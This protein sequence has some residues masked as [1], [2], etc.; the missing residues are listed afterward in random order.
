MLKRTLLAF[1][2]FV[3]ICGIAQKPYSV[4]AESKPGDSIRAVASIL[5]EELAKAGSSKY[6][7][8]PLTAFEGSGFRL[9]STKQAEQFNIKF[10]EGLKKFGPEGIY[11]NA[12]NQSA[13]I[14]GNSAL[15]IQEGIYIYLEQLGYRWFLPGEKWTITPGLVSVFKPVSIL[16]QPDFEYRTIAN[17]HGYLNLE[18][19]KKDYDAWYKANRM[20]GAYSIFLGHNYDNIV[21]ARADIFKQHPEYFAE[22][23]VKGNLP[24]TAKFNVANKDL[25]NLVIDVAKKDIEGQIKAN[26]SPLFFSMEPSDGGGYCQKPECLAIGGSSEQAFYLANEVAKALKK[27]PGATVGSYAYNEHIVPPKFNLEKNFLVMVTNGFNRS[28]YSTEQLLQMWKQKVGKVGVYEY[29]SVFEGHM[30]MPGKHYA[31]NTTYLAKSVKSF[32]NSG[33]RYYNGESTIGW[34]NKG[35]GQYLLTKLLWNVNVNADSI[36]NDYYQK[37]FDNAAGPM[38]K[39]FQSWEHHAFGVPFPHELADWHALIDEA[40][41]LAKSNDVRTRIDDVKIYLHYVVLYTEVQT[42]KSEEVIQK[43]LNY[44][45]RTKEQAL[46]ATVPALVSL[47]N[48]AGF[49]ALAY[50]ANPVQKWKSNEGPLT[51]QEIQQN[52][53]NDTEKFRNAKGV[54]AFK[55]ADT[56]TDLRSVTAIQP[57][58]YRESPHSFW[59]MTEYIIRINKKGTDNFFEIASGH[60]ANPPL[61]RDVEVSFIPLK[62]PSAKPIAQFNQRKKTEKEKFSLAALSEGYYKVV[63]QDHQKMFVL[64]FSKGIDYSIIMKP[65]Q[66]IHTTSAA[67]LNEFYFYVPKG[68]KRFAVLKAVVMTLESPKKRLLNYENNKAETFYVDVQPGEEGLWSIHNQA[69]WFFIE[70]VPPYLGAHPSRMLVPTYLKN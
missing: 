21:A 1:S 33:A 67:G 54:V 36:K 12:T 65:G 45:W 62:D 6:T 55:S 18:K 3:C 14:I 9:L 70:G 27:Y 29:L 47:A 5:F 58:N 44:A 64:N 8:L 22:P 56:F 40:Y 68:T 41:K 63:V 26:H 61:D 38:R 23:I 52:F 16:T 43:V 25:V 50:Y 37:L 42:N 10:P 13:T 7:F 48:Y 59:G 31:S 51:S 19:P 4:Y 2:L 15:A 69:G 17:G 34:I 11:I 32:H 49:P 20:G 35:L 39:L 28:K 46:F 24:V 66:I 60:A 30:D 53:K 57:I